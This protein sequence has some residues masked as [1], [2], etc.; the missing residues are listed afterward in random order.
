[1]KKAFLF[2]ILF[3]IIISSLSFGDSEF[4]ESELDDICF[5]EGFARYCDLSTFKS[6]CSYS[7]RGN[8][9]M[10]YEKEMD[11]WYLTQ[12]RQVFSDIVEDLTCTFSEPEF[13]D[14]DEDKYFYSI[15]NLNIKDYAS[16]GFDIDCNDINSEIQKLIYG[17]EGSIYAKG[18]KDERTICCS[19][20]AKEED[21]FFDYR[22]GS[23][24]MPIKCFCSKDESTNKYTKLADISDGSIIYA[25]ICCASNQKFLKF[26]YKTENDGKL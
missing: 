22:E 2:F 26:L 12:C 3:L 4:S 18:N 24:G 8:G 19:K 11:W 16:C 1:M 21:V 20:T 13:K 5:G 7:F 25:T 9:L 14:E 15:S 17:E 6:D 10:G 23:L